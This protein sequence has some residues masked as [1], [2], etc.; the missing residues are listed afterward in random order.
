[1]NSQS[2]CNGWDGVGTS[3]SDLAPSDNVYNITLLATDGP[4]TD[5]QALQVF[6]RNVSG[7]TIIGTKKANAVDAT[8]DIASRA[9]TGEDD[10][11]DGK[12]GNEKLNGLAG[13]R[14]ARWQRR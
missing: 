11:I 9:A 12:K 2:W 13:K 10:Y 8:H 1:M 6:G 4:L 7:N 14:H 3:T 5:T